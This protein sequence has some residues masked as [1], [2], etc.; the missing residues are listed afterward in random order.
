MIQPFH[1]AIKVHNLDEARAFYGEL[2]GFEEGRSNNSWIDW[3]FF[4]HQLVTHLDNSLT[5]ENINNLVDNK[6]IPVPHFGVV[7]EWEKWHQ[8]AENLKQKQIKFIVEPYIRFRGLIGEQATMFFLDYSGNALEFK[9]FQNQ[10]QLFA[11]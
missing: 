1:L 3:N 8:F 9:S 6:N 4:G 10:S 7:L 2:L 5:I 11:K